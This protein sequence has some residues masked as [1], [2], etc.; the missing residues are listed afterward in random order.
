MGTVTVYPT[1]AAAGG[2]AYRAPEALSDKHNLDNFNCGV[3][4]LNQWLQLRARDSEGKTA[5]T[6]VLVRTDPER[7]EQV[8]GFYCLALGAVIRKDLPR[9]LR[10][11]TPDQIPIIVIGRFAI[12]QDFKKQGLGASLLRDAILR[13]LAIADNAGMRAIVVH[14]T[15]DQHGEEAAGFYQ[16]YDFIPSPINPRTFVLPVEVAK[17]AL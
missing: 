14:V 12:H 11:N 17:A 15:D 13:S 6:F 2:P 9:K 7:G 8:V 5:R 1:T 10:A 3:E 16:K 4:V